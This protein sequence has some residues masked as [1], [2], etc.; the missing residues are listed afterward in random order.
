MRRGTGQERKE[1]VG[2]SG[3]STRDGGKR[4]VL[5]DWTSWDLWIGPFGP[6]GTE[7]GTCIDPGNERTD[8][9]MFILLCVQKA[10]TSANSHYMSQ[11]HV[12]ICRRNW[13]RSHRNHLW[14]MLR[15]GSR[16][17]VQ[18]SCL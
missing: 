4:R 6:G 11:G 12:C 17:A 13:I 3:E 1:G 8:E 5:G 15:L 10:S 7:K 14:R 9:G 18:N 2:M 16:H